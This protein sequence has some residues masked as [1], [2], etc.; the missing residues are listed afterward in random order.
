MPLHRNR[1]QFLVHLPIV[2]A[3]L[4]RATAPLTLDHIALQVYGRAY[5]PAE[6]F[7]VAGILDCLQLE[8]LNCAGVMGYC[9]PTTY[10]ALD[11]AGLLAPEKPVLPTLREFCN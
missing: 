7:A 5:S 6:W 11:Q 3:M 8:R 4:E 2:Q 10:A 1:R 9:L